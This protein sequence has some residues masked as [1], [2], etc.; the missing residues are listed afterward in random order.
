MRKT[1]W[2]INLKPCSVKFTKMIS[3]KLN[4]FEMFIKKLYFITYLK[5]KD[6]SKLFY[7]L[8]M[9][10]Y[11]CMQNSVIVLFVM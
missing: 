5:D 2:I 8:P 3:D 10:K 1:D 6:Q 9:T 11:V 4:I 7:K